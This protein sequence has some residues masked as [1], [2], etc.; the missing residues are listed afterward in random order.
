MLS[1]NWWGEVFCTFGWKTK[2]PRHHIKQTQ[3]HLRWVFLCAS[4]STLPHRSRVLRYK[5]WKQRT[6]VDSAGVRLYYKN[7]K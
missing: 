1:D 7:K 6:A 2:T 3:I 4:R 5:I